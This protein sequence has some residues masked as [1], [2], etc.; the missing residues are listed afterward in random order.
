MLSNNLKN[1][2]A[3]RKKGNFRWAVNETRNEGKKSEFIK[4][5]LLLNVVTVGTESFVLP[6]SNTFHYFFNIAEELWS[7][8]VLQVCELEI[9]TGSEIWALRKVVKQLPVEMLQQCW[10]ANSCM[11]KRIVMGE[12]YTGYQHST[13]SFLNGQRSYFSVSTI[14]SPAALIPPSAL[15]FRPR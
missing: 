2:S 6:R 13:P 15:L 4:M 7:Q 10:I 14:V 3:V 12:H 1:T 9:V 8:P 11:R 5:I